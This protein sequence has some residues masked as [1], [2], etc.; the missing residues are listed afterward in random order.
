MREERR[1]VEHGAGAVRE[2]LD[3]RAEP[4]PR[5][6]LAGGAVAELRLVA[7]REQRLAA[8]CALPRTRYLEHLV[9]GQI[10]PFPAPRRP[11][12]RAVVA[13]VAA[14]LRQRHEDL[15]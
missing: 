15:R 5:E 13:D 11:C 2:V 8:A 1:L 6:L 9:H 12:E 14:E 7:E 4:E 10:R 3:R